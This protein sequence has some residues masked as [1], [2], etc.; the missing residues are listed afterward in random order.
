M[1]FTKMHG[2]GND[3]VLIDCIGQVC[4][5]DADDLS[6]LSR[7]LCH[8]RFGIGADQILLLYPSDVADYKMRI[9]NADGGEVEMCGNGIRCLAKYIWDRNLSGKPVLDIETQ[10]GIIKQEKAGD[11]VKVDMGEPAFEP[12]KIPV[13]ADSVF[14][15]QDSRLIDYP[16]SAGDREFNVTSV[17]M[18]NPHAVIFVDDVSSFP[19]ADYGPVIE[20]HS[21]FP[22]K[23]NVEFVQVLSGKDIRMRVWERGSGETMACGTGASAAAVASSIKGLTGR[24]VSVHLTGGDLIIEWAGNNHVYMTGPAAEVF[25]GVIEI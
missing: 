15:I 10:A 25:E 7:R 23:T 11:M 21:M 9:F 22:R 20:T 12:E 14:K 19:V 18:G 2:I 24:N 13:K 16:L 17:S 4:P 8:R 1:K 3:F 5:Q 6:A